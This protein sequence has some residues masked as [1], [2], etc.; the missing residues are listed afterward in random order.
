MLYSYYT[1]VVRSVGTDVVKRACQAAADET[2]VTMLVYN[3]FNWLHCGW[4][5]S[6]SHGSVQHDQVSGMLIII[7]VNEQLSLPA[8]ARCCMA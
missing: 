3:N 8:V 7:C 6:T 5:V 4:E 1:K 2:L